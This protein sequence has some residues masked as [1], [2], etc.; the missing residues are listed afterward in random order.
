[1]WENLRVLV[2]HIVDVCVVSG[3]TT[4]RDERSVGRQG[5]GVVIPGTDDEIQGG[6]VRKGGQCNIP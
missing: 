2:S 3:M 6:A 5:R 4:L 1:M